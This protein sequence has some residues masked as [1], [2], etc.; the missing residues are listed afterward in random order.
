MTRSDLAEAIMAVRRLD[1]DHPLFIE[2]GYRINT[3]PV[4]RMADFVLYNIQ[5]G[6][7]GCSLYSESGVG[8]STAQDYLVETDWRWLVEDGRRDRK[9]TRLNSSPGYN[10]YARF[11]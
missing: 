6:H 1:P 11:C 10:S 3:K 7:H 8:K 2:S 9:S 4:E 5:Q